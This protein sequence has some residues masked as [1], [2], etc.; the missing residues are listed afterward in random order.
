METFKCFY[1]QKL[2]KWI[3][4]IEVY[5]FHLSKWLFSVFLKEKG[6]FVMCC[7]KNPFFPKPILVLKSFLIIIFQLLNGS[8]KQHLWYVHVMSFFCLCFIH[9]TSPPRQVLPW[10]LTYL[11]LFYVIFCHY[12]YISSSVK[13]PNYNKLI[14]VFIWFTCMS[15]VRGQS[16][17]VYQLIHLYCTVVSN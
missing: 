9:F 10:L 2:W 6:K 17:Y 8:Q 16:S 12:Q 13:L 4:F 3:Y 7:L 11:P 5:A 1:K 14:Y 15:A